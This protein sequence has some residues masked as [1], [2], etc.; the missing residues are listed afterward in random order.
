MS[1]THVEPSANGL[2]DDDLRWI[3][4]MIHDVRADIERHPAWRARIEIAIDNLLWSASVDVRN[5]EY[6]VQDGW[7][8]AGQRLRELHFHRAPFTD[9][10]WQAFKDG[11]PKEVKREHVVPR[12]KLKRI[13]CSTPGIDETLRV[14]R[15]YARVALVHKTECRRLTH[16]RMPQRWDDGIDWTNPPRALPDPWE[17]YRVADPPVVP[18]HH[19]GRP[20]FDPTVRT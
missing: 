6:V 11:V 8:A 20:A 15:A 17:R 5:E 14:L 4:A 7:V 16:D 18:R 13:V 9:L 10:A 19:D 3:A 12:A 2:S 1:L